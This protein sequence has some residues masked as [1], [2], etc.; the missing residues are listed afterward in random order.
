MSHTFIWMKTAFHCDNCSSNKGTNNKLSCMTLNAWSLA[1]IFL[2]PSGPKLSAWTSVEVYSN[3]E[4]SILKI[5]SYFLQVRNFVIIETNWIINLIS[6]WTKSW[7]TND[8]WTMLLK[9]FLQ[10]VIRYDSYLQCAWNEICDEILME[11]GPERA[12]TWFDVVWMLFW[13]IEQLWSFWT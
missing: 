2:G 9:I 4:K 11:T 6:N 5:Q 12:F 7:A 13:R 1:W 10:N 3:L 8:T